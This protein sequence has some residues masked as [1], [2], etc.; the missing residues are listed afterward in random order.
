[1]NIN[2]LTLLSCPRHD[3]GFR[4]YVRVGG[5]FGKMT[6]SLG[7][8]ERNTYVKDLG[9]TPRADRLDGERL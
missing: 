8:Q 4:D 9:Y 2:L 5:R 3:L 1:M 7:I 6:S